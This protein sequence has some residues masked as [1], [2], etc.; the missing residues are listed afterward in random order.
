MNDLWSRETDT[1]HVDKVN[2]YTTIKTVNANKSVTFVSTRALDTGLQNS[3]AIEPD[4]DI[5][6]CFAFN[7]KT[8]QLHNHENDRGVFTMRLNSDGTTQV[9][10]S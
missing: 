6:M 10:F 2:P 1:P 8:W 4:K 5:T 3:Y 7:Q 9:L